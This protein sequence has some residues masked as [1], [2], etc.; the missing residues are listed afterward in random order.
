[1]TLAPWT[2]VRPTDFLN[3]TVAGG[4]SGARL[5]Q[6]IQ[7]AREN[8][9]RLNLESA[10]QTQRAREAGAQMRMQGDQAAAE[11]ALRHN[12]LMQQHQLALGKLSEANAALA[13]RQQQIQQVGQLA[14]QKDEL[15]RDR[16]SR[17]ASAADELQRWHNG[18][19]SLGER[20]LQTQ[21][22][23]KNKDRIAAIEKQASALGAKLLTLPPNDPN[24]DVI[25][26]QQKILLG[27]MNDLR[28]GQAQPAAVSLS[29]QPKPAAQTKPKIFTDKTGQKYNYTGN[30]DDPSKD[31]DPN[32]WQMVQ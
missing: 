11:L 28:S 9:S 10:A 23:E 6:I 7:S 27:R 17:L 5:G 12:Q 19:L 30:L 21:S 3:A 24:I 14:Q 26:G 18:E 25:R 29:A 4:E 20:K 13:L 15:L 16:E 32:N 2:E 8:A 22:E 31:Q 1:M